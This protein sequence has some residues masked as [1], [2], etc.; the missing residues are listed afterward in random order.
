M[1][2]Q[3]KILVVDDEPAIR[4]LLGAG[5]AR[6]GY[7]VVE[8]AS[9]RDA[10]SAMQIDKPE[11]VLLDLGLP[12]R[13]G[14]ELVPLLKAAGASVIVVSA[15]DATEQKVTAL[16]LGADDYVTKP[17][18]TE[19]VLAR[20]RTALRHRLSVEAEMPVVRIDAIEI[21][22][23]ARLVRRAGE[24]VHLTPKEFGFLA[25]LA[26]H[27]G[28]VVTHAQLLRTV[29]GPGHEHDVEYLRVA[30]RGVRRKLEGDAAAPS[31]I[32]NEPGVGYRLMA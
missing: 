27:P 18:D 7:R 1:S 24:E 5:L 31:V 16:D 15:R 19:E 20:V 25:E 4:R 26:K 14:L 28:R 10:L 13:D 2:Q 6:A 17:F 8:A 3:A 32:R 30:A 12:D 9:A 29:W 23:G 22:L 11:A 21:D